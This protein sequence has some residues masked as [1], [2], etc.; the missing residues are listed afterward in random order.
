MYRKNV[1]CFVFNEFVEFLGCV[2]V[3]SDYLQCVQGGVEKDDH[4]VVLTAMREIKEEIGLEP[5]DV[6][7]VGEVPPPDNN[8]LNFRYEL[9]PT[10]N[11]R[12]FG[13]R[14]QEQRILLFFVWSKTINK[15]VLVPPRNQAAPQE[16]SRVEWVSMKQLQQR[17]PPEKA[18]IFAAVA[19]VAPAMASEFLK[20]SGIAPV[21]SSV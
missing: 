15:M 6:R 9:S 7:Y 11:L 1:C 2:R 16:F 21:K 4:D 14:G 20:A 3:N 19:A 18:H 5:S 17:C 10:A 12:R 8:P 13:F